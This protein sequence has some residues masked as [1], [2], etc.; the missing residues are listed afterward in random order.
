MHPPVQSHPPPRQARP[1]TSPAMADDFDDFKSAPLANQVQSHV[2]NT[3]P[4]VAQLPTATDDDFTDFKT[5]PAAVSAQQGVTSDQPVPAMVEAP[6]DKSK[7]LCT[8]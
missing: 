6:A 4:F 2:Q 8:V 7:G 5:A 3:A 1:M